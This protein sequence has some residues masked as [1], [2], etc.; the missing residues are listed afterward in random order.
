MFT[1]NA[2]TL[3]E[4]D[5]G[6]VE[7]C[8][9]SKSGPVNKF[10]QAT[11]AEL[12]QA[13]SLLA[14]HS[15][16]T[17]VL[18]TSSKSTFIVGA[19]ITEFSGVFVKSFDEICDWTHQTHRTFQQLEQ[20]P[21]PVVA[22]INGATMGGGLELALLAD[23]RVIADTAK[24]AL[25]EVTLGI[26]PGW[27]G[28]V[29]LSRLI[30]WQAALEWMLTGKHQAAIDA[31]KAGAV[32]LVVTPTALREA[33]LSTLQSLVGEEKVLRH[34]EALV[35]NDDEQQ[36]LDVFCE[37]QLAK[38]DPRYPAAI[39]ILKA[40]AKHVTLP[41]AEAINE[42]VKLFAGL[43]KTDS[44]EALVGNFV[45]Q[46]T[47]ARIGKRMAGQVNP[48]EKAAVLGAGIMG[49]GIAYQTAKSGIPIVMKDIQ[50]PA[51]DLGIATATKIL[52]KLVA[53]GRSSEDE[54]AKVL[55]NITP[56][57]ELG[58]LSDAEVVVEAVVENP[59]IKSVVLAETEANIPNTSVLA[60]NTSTISIDFLAE[61]LARPHLFCGIH[62]FNPVQ[63]MPLVEIIRGSKTSDDT[64]AR[65]V[66]YALS[67]RKTP[68]VVNDCP[69]FL[70][71]R[72][73]FPYFHGF[74][75]LLQDGVSMERI[76]KVMENF[77]WPMGPAYLAD[78]IGMDTMV[79]ADDGLQAGFPERMTHANGY[80][81]KTLLDANLL[82]QKN[83]EGFYQY[84]TDENGRRVKL[85]S[86]IAQA[87]IDQAVQ[88]HVEVSDEDIIY[89]MMIPMCT[90]SVRCLDENIVNSAA[91]LDM[92]LL[93]GLGFPK[94]RG[95]AIRYLDAIGT[96][97]FAEIAAQ[98]ADLG[99]LYQLTEELAARAAK[100]S[101]VYA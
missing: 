25:P 2:I 38:L 72:V 98:Y 45:N 33:A 85:P 21:V 31:E 5:A 78:V 84:T 36:A 13:V 96:A 3:T 7:L 63:A 23:R 1:G 73:L 70:V 82:G 61:N 14:Q 28:T 101:K 35:L 44:A 19:D 41:F 47:V 87:L 62:F 11:L 81:L 26:C 68:I 29:R 65:A 18:I 97:K 16:L 88:R 91:E 92:A 40:I 54:K 94:F 95:G 59:K 34:T 75:L 37:Q 22:A 42:E 55:A 10:D 17:G 56:T 48:I 8:F 50:Q 58:A 90:E 15:A 43:A 24:I 86:A 69:G 46:Q 49:G 51:L 93:M 79:H 4:L 89:R 64:I 100:G 39:E 71:N 27:G 66:A 67:L 30:G 74:N 9:D 57:L 60:S 80:V 6:L 32:D 77:G 52:D 20:L 99:G 83:G 76:D 12:A 53:K